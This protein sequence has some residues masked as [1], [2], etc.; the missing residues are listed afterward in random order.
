MRSLNVEKKEEYL[1]SSYACTGQQASMWLYT[2][3][4][5]CEANHIYLLLQVFICFKR[6]YCQAQRNSTSFWRLLSSEILTSNTFHTLISNPN[7]LY[8]CIWEDH[9]T[10]TIMQLFPSKHS[11]PGCQ[12]F[13]LHH[14]SCSCA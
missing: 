1:S 14:L 8:C 13:F 5:N 12:L 6:V 11:F 2:V 3:R 10:P 4:Q 7:F 9:R